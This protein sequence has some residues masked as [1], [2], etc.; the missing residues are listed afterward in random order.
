MAR[1]AAR[2]A[3]FLLLAPVGCVVWPPGAG[4]GGAEMPIAEALEKQ[5][6]GEA[7][8]VDVRSPEAYAAGHIPGALNVS[9]YG[10]ES[11]VPELRKMG[12]TLILY[13]G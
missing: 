8:L 1:T 13:C 4:P 7:V 9:P 11:K 2:I 5:A 3:I 12:R 10:I 6:R